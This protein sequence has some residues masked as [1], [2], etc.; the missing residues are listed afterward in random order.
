M[1]LF[2]LFAFAVF[3]CLKIDLTKSVLPESTCIN[4]NI[5]FTSHIP[6]FTERKN[7][8]EKTQGQGDEAP[9]DGAVASPKPAFVDGNR[10]RYARDQCLQN[11]GKSSASWDD[12]LACSLDWERFVALR[13]IEYA[14]DAQ[15]VDRP[16]NRAPSRNSMRSLALVF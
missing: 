13:P 15:Q 11:T 3:C 2:R 6:Q 5:D 14:A 4:F 10:S 9:V 16:I 12:W 8:I 1:F 7:R